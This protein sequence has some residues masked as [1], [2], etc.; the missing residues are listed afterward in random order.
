MVI[1]R[2]QIQS[3]PNQT[4]DM[5]SYILNELCLPFRQL[6]LRII[7][8]AIIFHVLYFS[9]INSMCV[10]CTF[11]SH[12]L[13]DSRSFVRLYSCINIRARVCECVCVIQH[14]NAYQ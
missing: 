14:I 2:K 12:T 7:R 4:I 6:R 8:D 3:K 11:G 5:K 1:R 10:Y 13:Y 9:F